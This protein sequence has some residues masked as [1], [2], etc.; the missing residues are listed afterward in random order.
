MKEVSLSN[1]SSC[2]EE[3]LRE[4]THSWPPPLTAIHTPGKAEQ[5]K[6]PIPSK[7]S[8]HL[9]SG[10][11][12][13]KRCNVS[14]N[15]T[16]TKPVPQKSM[17]EDDLKL[18]SDEDESEQAA[19]KTKQRSTP[20]KSLC[21]TW[22]PALFSGG[23]S[24]GRETLGAISRPPSPPSIPPSRNVAG[25]SDRKAPVAKRRRRVP[26]TALLRTPRGGRDSLSQTP[27]PNKPPPPRHH[28]KNRGRA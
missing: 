20:L 19:E 4:M 10:Y 8:Q 16:A 25:V 6:F 24:L 26:G 27:P 18:S 14:G 2:V 1:D 3:I 12:G 21:E 11:N 23:G 28:L 22:P 13:Q 17:L 7:D 5:T 15:K 9:T